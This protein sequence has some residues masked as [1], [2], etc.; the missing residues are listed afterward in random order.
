MKKI[1][2]AV[3]LVATG[4]VANAQSDFKPVKGDVTAEF[5]LTG[6]VLNADFKLNET[7][8]VLRGR[9]FFQDKTA[10]RVGFGLT[11]NSQ[12][13]NAYNPTNADQ[14]GTVE[15]SDT[16]LLINLG[17]EKHFTGTD[18]LSPYVGGDVLF[19]YGSSSTTFDNATGSV[20]APTYANGSSSSLDGPSA[21]GIGLRAVMGAD[22]YFAK[23]LYLG[24]EAGFGF[25]Y[26][27]E[28]KTTLSSTTPG[29]STT[30]TNE[31]AGHAF[32]LDK[33]VITGLRIGFV[34]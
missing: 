18:R 24:A 20:N 17:I 1:L 5:G 9:Y 31:S 16:Q 6:G 30:V 8:N 19:G 26:T 7:G 15:D 2:F 27:K 12:T 28:G 32:S 14:K 21:F 23:H 4:F 11:S 25:L 13:N 3:A 29:G 33:S 34:F 22:Y 10:L